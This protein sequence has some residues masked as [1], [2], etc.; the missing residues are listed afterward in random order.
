MTERLAW[1]SH[2]ARKEW[3]LVFLGFAKTHGAFLRLNHGQR[4][5]Q[6]QNPRSLA[7][8]NH[9]W[10]TWNKWASAL[11]LMKEATWVG[12]LAVWTKD[13]TSRRLPTKLPSESTSAGVKRQ[14]QQGWYD[15][16]VHGSADAAPT[17]QSVHAEQ[18]FPLLHSHRKTAST[19]CCGHID[20][21]LSAN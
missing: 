11:S 16:E 5:Q 7:G 10:R 19:L 1:F 4:E 15:G 21:P 2:R 8:L 12:W 6:F 13:S 17:G 9:S 18:T 3:N 20:H 14:R